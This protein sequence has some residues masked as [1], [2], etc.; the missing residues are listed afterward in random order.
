[1][2][3]PFAQ[4][5]FRARFEWGEQGLRT[6]APHVDL[7][8][9][10]DVLSFT[11][12]VDVATSRGAGVIPYR[13]RD[14][15][16]KAFADEHGAMLAV[17]RYDVSQERP[18]SLSPRTLTAISPGTRLVL[19]S[20]NGSTLTTVAAETHLVAA[21]CLRNA[22]AVASWTCNRDT[23]G[24]IAAGELRRDGSLRFAIE[25]LVGAGAILSHLPPEARSPEA[26]V[27]VAAFERFKDDLPGNLAA[28]ASGRELA[29]IGFDDDVAMAAELD[30][31]TAMPLFVTPGW[32][33]DVSS[34]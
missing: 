7:V 9:I 23:V 26:E 18:Y 19:P 33:A 20:P 10:V 22:R 30:V 21:G 29:A 27:A 4:S 3:G 28:C 11:T 13:F 32:Y 24:V 6:L 5:G 2:E 14:D 16:A 17:S 12:A 31:S 25:D 8:V 15:S 1:V 34:V